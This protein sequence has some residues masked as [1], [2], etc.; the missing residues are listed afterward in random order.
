MNEQVAAE[1]EVHR[2][3]RVARRVEHDEAAARTG[4]VP[5]VRLDQLRHDVGPGVVDLEAHLAQPVEI[6]ARDVEDRSDR[7]RRDQAGQ[8]GA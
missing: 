3:Q 7:A 6:A 1:D 2:G 8:R 4:M 5:L